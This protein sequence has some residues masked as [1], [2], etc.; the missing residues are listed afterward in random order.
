MAQTAGVGCWA[1]YLSSL[2]SVASATDRADRV[3]REDVLDERALQVAEAATPETA[4]APAPVDWTPMPF[5]P[6]ERILWGLEQGF[7]VA[8]GPEGWSRIA[9]ALPSAK[10][11][12]E[13][14]AFAEGVAGG[15]GIAIVDIATEHIKLVKDG[16]TAVLDFYSVVFDVDIWIEMMKVWVAPEGTGVAEFAKFMEAEHP[17]LHAAV[18][19]YFNLTS[20]LDQFIERLSSEETDSGMDWPEAWRT[21]SDW[22]ADFSQVMGGRLRQHVDALVASKGNAGAQGEIIGRVV[23]RIVIESVLL[24]MDLYALVQGAA[25]LARGVFAGIRELR[26]PAQLTKAVAQAEKSTPGIIA[27]GKNVAKGSDEAMKIYEALATEIGAYKNLRR[28]TGEFN[29]R[30][31]DICGLKLADTDYIAIRLD[32]Q[33]IVENTW[34]NKFA[35]DFKKA[36]GWQS[37]N[38]MD[39]IALHTEWHIR[40][41]ANLSTDIGLVGAEKEVSLTKALQDHLLKAQVAPD[42]T[43]KPFTNLRGLFEA[44]ADFYQTYSPRLWPR[45]EEWFKARIAQ[46]STSTL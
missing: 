23:A 18:T 34:Y 2:A 40:S 10:S 16:V 46:L 1:Q 37:G 35:D 27:A 31:R 6:G 20:K 28:R 25:G 41:G 39:A 45:L 11:P 4:I 26:T 42:G 13:V 12:E 22:I 14:T 43:P 24:A 19:S 36:F 29:R 30:V 9:V 33:H 32:A 5:E 44:H 21:I 8:M 17:D 15:V 38:D 7:K 3:L